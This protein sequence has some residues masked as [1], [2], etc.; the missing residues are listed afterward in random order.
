MLKAPPLS[1]R[2]G[3]RLTRRTWVPTA[4]AADMYIQPLKLHLT[5]DFQEA[6]RSFVEKRAPEYRAR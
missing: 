1:A 5:E 6:S 3:V 2:A 4:A